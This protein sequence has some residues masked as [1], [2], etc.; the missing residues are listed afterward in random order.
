VRD[1]F[2][3][4]P[5]VTHLNHGSFG[6]VPRVVA[7]HQRRIKQRADANPQR[8]FR[9]EL[10]ELKARAREAAGKFLGVSADELALVRN[11]TESV[12]T[13]LSSLAWQRRLGP[14]DVVL[15][16]EQGYGA[17]APAVAQWCSRTGASYDVVP[18]AVDATPEQVVEGCRTAMS[19]AVA[20]GDAVRLVIVDQITS[21]TGSLL[22]VEAVCALAHEHGALAFVD[23]AHAPGQVEV[24]PPET[25]ADFWTGTWHKWGFAPRGTSA[26]WVGEAERDRITPVTTSWNHGEP[27]PLPFDTH[28]T[29][30]Y[31]GWLCLEAAVTFWREAGGFGI[32]E[33]ARSLLDDGAAVVASSVASTDL[34]VS[35]GV[36]LSP[37]PCLRLVALPDGVATTEE[38]AGA[39]YRTLSALGVETQVLAYG[40]RGW[41]RL[42]GAVYNVPGDYAR[43]ADVLPAA[44][45]EGAAEG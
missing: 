2:F 25:G 19:R 45:L 7:E 6:A 18:L 31:S 24:V 13:V 32:G 30:D 14:G 20:R 17:V 44:P 37:A 39:L 26:L 38:T 15:T 4:D 10:P 5:T 36:P 3:L 29:D 11:P 23:G 43:L 35:P 22:P 41:I 12:A 33:R 16:T 42:S 27:F 8:F 1:A 28:G 21:P 40:G 9:V 34:A